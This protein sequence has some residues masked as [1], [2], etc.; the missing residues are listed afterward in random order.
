MGAANVGLRTAENDG[1]PWT[2][3]VSPSGK[4]AARQR[5]PLEYPS[6]QDLL[7]AP[8]SSK[9]I[10]LVHPYKSQEPR[11][12]SGAGSAYSMSA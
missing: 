4:R 7:T 3:Y 9:A 11:L 6:G 2:F 10:R 8:W 1:R 5:P 12:V